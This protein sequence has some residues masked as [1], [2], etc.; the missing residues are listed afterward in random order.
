MAKE[1]IKGVQSELRT[2]VELRKQLEEWDVADPEALALSIQSETNLEEAIDAV[3]GEIAER[4]AAITG[5]KEREQAIAERRRR[6]EK[7]VDT[8]RAVILQ[9]LDMAGVDKVA[10]PEATISVKKVKPAAEVVE[11]ADIPSEFWEPQPPKLNKKALSEALANGQTV[12]GARL[13][14]GGITL[15]IRKK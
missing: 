15:A 12:E 13:G 11:E 10:L 3:F 5:L 14:N 6:H 7:T 1:L 2:A 9:A 4:E 8:L